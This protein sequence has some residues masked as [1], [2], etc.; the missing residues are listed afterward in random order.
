MP[1]STR[2]YDLVAADALD[3]RE[4]VLQ[5]VQVCVDVGDDGEP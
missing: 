4:R 3:L 5:G 2:A 1:R